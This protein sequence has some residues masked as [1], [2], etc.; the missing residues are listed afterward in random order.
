MALTSGLIGM[1]IRSPRLK[2]LA[3][4]AQSP[5]LKQDHKY[6]QR[7]QGSNRIINMHK[8]SKAQTG[9]IHGKRVQGSTDASIGR[10]AQRVQY[11]ESNCAQTCSFN[12]LHTEE[13]NTG[14][15][16]VNLQFKLVT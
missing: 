8:E 14:S 12:L 13:F 1:N 16:T 10:S 15:Q 7:V 6:A 3:N 9:N 4:N 11:F 5:R 2:Q